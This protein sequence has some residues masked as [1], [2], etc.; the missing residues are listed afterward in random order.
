MLLF[1][2]SP[3]FYC[4]SPSFSF[5]ILHLSH[6]PFRSLLQGVVK[7][8]INFIKSNHKEQLKLF[9]DNSPQLDPHSM[10]IKRVKKRERKAKKKLKEEGKEKYKK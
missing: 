5:L 7:E 10:H 2:I 3:E 6:F 8:V 1:E 9:I 4:V